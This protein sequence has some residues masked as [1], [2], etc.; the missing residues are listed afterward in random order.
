V[1]RGTTS[2]FEAE[3]TA[4]S[5]IVGRADADGWSAA[6]ASDPSGY[7]QY[8]PYTTAP[9]ATESTASFTLMVDNNSADNLRVVNLDV[10][11]ATAGV[12]RATRPVA[13]RELQ[14][15]W[16]Y[17]DFDVRFSATKLPNHLHEFRVW[18]NDVSYVRLDRVRVGTPRDLWAIAM[19]PL[20]F[21]AEN[22]SHI[23]GRADAD[24]WSAATALDPVG[25]LL[26]GPYTD[27]ARPGAR[28][29]TFRLMVDNATADNL[30]VVSLDVYDATAGVIR[31][32]EDVHR[33]DLVAPFIYKDFRV[34]FNA[35]GGHL[36]EFRVWW[37]RTS[38]VRV[39]RVT[40]Q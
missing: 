14:L 37:D 22:G 26:Y 29:A 8:G 9:P 16:T 32:Q 18:W 31:A 19:S 24:G 23:I 6:T 11:D 38:Y 39:D 4:V 28:S 17:Q 3:G 20:V 33:Q 2:T 35:V 1:P 12:V 10:Y 13:R 40:L 27:Q 15:P 36:H 30:R 5:H 34:T 7:L 25:Y 21:E